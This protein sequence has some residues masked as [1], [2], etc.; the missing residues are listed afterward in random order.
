V[1]F[2]PADL[3]AIPVRQ[4]VQRR[5]R[6]GPFAS[7]RDLVKFLCFATVGA[8]IAAVTSA[9]VWLPFLAA[10]G[11]I[12]FIRV[13]GQT[14]DEYALGY[15]RFRQRASR[16]AGFLTGPAR[17]GPGSP[18]SRRRA[19]P[20]LRA[21]GIPIVYLPPADLQR[22]FEEW[23]SA[24][25]AVDGSVGFRTRGELFSPL[26]FLPASGSPHGAEREALDSYRD[27]VRSLLRQ[28]YRR[29][30]DVKVAT[31]GLDGEP[32][33]LQLQTQ[34]DGLLATLDR[35]GIPAQRTAIVTATS[36]T[37]GGEVP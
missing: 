11:M 9:V 13:E 28:R 34:L 33:A 16:S 25:S 22:V 36:R 5:L 8:A 23:R 2:A 29:V 12:A 14:L 31:P 20:S 7:G 19:S 4:L 37:D 27:M 21:G 35:L 26:P 24:L 1:E 30:V 3:S 6:L 17:P 15:C 32:A 18:G 10:G